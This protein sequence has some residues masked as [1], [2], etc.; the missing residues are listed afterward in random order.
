MYE[1]FTIFASIAVIKACSE[2]KCSQ[3]STNSYHKAS[4]VLLSVERIMLILLRL[5]MLVEILYSKLRIK[6]F[7]TLQ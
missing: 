4:A 5:S 2:L 6:C 3:K 1:I 7:R